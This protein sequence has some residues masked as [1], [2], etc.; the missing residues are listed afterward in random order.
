M[1]GR[2]CTADLLEI[3]TYLESALSAQVAQEPVAWMRNNR[4]ECITA[5]S[6]KQ[7]ENT[8]FGCWKEVATSYTIPLYAAP[9]ADRSQQEP[10]MA[11]GITKLSD[12]LEGSTPE[13]EIL[14]DDEWTKGHEE[15]K[16][17][18]FKVVG[19]QPRAALQ[20]K[21]SEQS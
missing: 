7:M 18:L 5:E 9:P 20:A 2:G 4:K 21:S 3:K 10:V 19:C 1:A 6:K 14:D 15:C 16:R 12:Y 13:S 17:R 8:D 11:D